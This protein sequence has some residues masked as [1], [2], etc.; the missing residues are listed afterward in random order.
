MHRDD[1]KFQFFIVKMTLT[2]AFLMLTFF[3]VG[4]IIGLFIIYIN[5]GKMATDLNHKLNEMLLS[6]P[7]LGPLL[8]WFKLHKNVG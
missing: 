4:K 3:F 8:E 7:A 1:N 6:I 5:S 2:G